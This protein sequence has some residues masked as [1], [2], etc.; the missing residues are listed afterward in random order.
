MTYVVVSDRL[1]WDE[2]TRLSVS[3]LDGC[4][5]DALVAAGHLRPAP[6][7]SPNPTQ[8]TPTPSEEE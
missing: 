8:D 3:E 4:N 5:I 1:R 2:G 7:K 6:K